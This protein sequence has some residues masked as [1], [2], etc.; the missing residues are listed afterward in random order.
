[1]HK[2]SKVFTTAPL[3]FMGQKRRFIKKVKEVIADYPNDA[4]YVDLFGG[5]GLLSH[6][7]K[8]NYPNSRV[9]Y[10]DFDNYRQRLLN[11]ERTNA[12]LKSIRETLK[13]VPKD[14]KVPLEQKK[15]IL[16]LIKKEIDITGYV[17]F[18]TISSSIL[19]SMKYVTSYDELEGQTFYN[20]VRESEY[21]ATG[22]LDG[23]DIECLDYKLLFEK[24]KHL[25]NVIWLVDPPYLSTET[26]TYKCSY[27]KLKDYLDVL[28]VLDG[29]NYIYFTSNKSQ[30]VELCEWIET[31]TYVG[32][33]FQGATT[34]TVDVQMNHSS[35]YTDVMLYKYNY[36]SK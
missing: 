14:A 12:V 28:N 7:I 20:T 10:N 8:T 4:V 21:D 36:I 35:K 6:T 19:F 26:G 24:Y 32:N 29:S 31:R 17:D 16:Q 15:S 3:P 13:V 22:Y 1:M 11:I 2:K 9:I 30:I 23:V 18:I 5:S 25:N 27:W 34:S 33:P